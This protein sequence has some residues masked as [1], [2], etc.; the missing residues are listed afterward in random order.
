MDVD[1]DDTRCRKVLGYR[2][3]FSTPQT[4]R[5]IVDTIEASNKT[6]DTLIAEAESKASGEALPSLSGLTEALK[7]EKDVPVEKRML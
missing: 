6:Q 4:I 3:K 2:N 7:K 5:W 1:V